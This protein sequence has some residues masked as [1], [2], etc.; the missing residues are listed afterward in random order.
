MNSLKEGFLFTGSRISMDSNF[1]H[2]RR[3]VTTNKSRKKA[4]SCWIETTICKIQP[5]FK[6]RKFK[7]TCDTCV[8]LCNEIMVSA[9]HVDS[10]G[11]KANFVTERNGS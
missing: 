4:G 10:K 2:R 3:Q 5:Q 7:E 1:C 11:P 8:K 9:A 6:L